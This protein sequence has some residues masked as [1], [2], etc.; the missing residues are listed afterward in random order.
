MSAPVLQR[1]PAPRHERVRTR[2]RVRTAVQ[3]ASAL[4]FTAGVLT[5]L[6]WPT[7]VDRPLYVRLLRALHRLEELG[8]SGVSYASLEAAANVALFVPLGFLACR[9][10]A[11]KRWWLAL[12][13]CTM[14][15]GA[16]ELAQELYLPER[17]G[18]A[19]DVLLNG[20]GALA[21]VGMAVL[22][23]PGRQRRLIR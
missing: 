14:L 12:L 6:L 11:P 2:S 18:N 21:G 4:L 3:L 16:G 19:E 9:L 22:L 20:A 7:P 15:S 10:L 13:A 1:V 5:V 8:L 17:V 23:R